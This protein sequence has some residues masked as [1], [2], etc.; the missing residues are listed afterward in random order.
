MEHETILLSRSVVYS[1]VVVEEKFACLL[2]PSSFV[3]RNRNIS[4]FLTSKKKHLNQ[5]IKTNF[6]IETIFLV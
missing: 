1:N 5:E 2:K 3:L 4:F 6:L